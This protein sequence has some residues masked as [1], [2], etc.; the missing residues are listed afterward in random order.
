VDRE[1]WTL[2]PPAS[3]THSLSGLTLEEL[4]SVGRKLGMASVEGKKADRVTAI[5]SFKTRARLQ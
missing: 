1:G 3:V 5:A 4:E 2:A